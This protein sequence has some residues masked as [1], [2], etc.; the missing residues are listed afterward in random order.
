MFSCSFPYFSFLLWCKL[1]VGSSRFPSLDFDH[2]LHLTV[3][4]RNGSRRNFPRKRTSWI[5]KFRITRLEITV[6]SHFSE[7]DLRKSSAK[8]EYRICSIRRRGYYLFHHVILCGFY[9]RA[10]TNR[11]RRLLNSVLP[12]KSFGNIRA[13]RKASFIRLT[14]NY[15]AVTFLIS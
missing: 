6:E 12:V 7:V 1:G 13:L 10:A 5:W 4:S 14:K 8:N 9:S 2:V 11:E 3:G 15:D